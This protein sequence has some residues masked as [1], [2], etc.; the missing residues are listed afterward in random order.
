MNSRESEKLALELATRITEAAI[1]QNGLNFS[2]EPS[3]KALAEFFGTIYHKIN[4][5]AQESE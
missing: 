4:A 3:V 2:H 5:L 1:P